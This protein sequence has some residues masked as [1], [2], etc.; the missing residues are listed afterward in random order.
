[1]RGWAG[2][3]W[4]GWVGGWVLN[5]AQGFCANA[6]FQTHVFWG[7][8]RACATN[9]LSRP[10]FLSRSSHNE[11]RGTGGGCVCPRKCIP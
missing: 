1:M 7:T 8:Q 11:R 2:L 10:L 4:G 3:G 5:K 9:H 6:Y